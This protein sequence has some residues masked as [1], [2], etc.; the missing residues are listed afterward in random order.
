[1][2]ATASVDRSSAPRDLVEPPRSKHDVGDLDGH[3]RAA[4]DGDADVGLAQRERIVHA[5]ADHRDDPPLGPQLADEP[6]LVLGQEIG[7]VV[8]EA[9]RARR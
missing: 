8:L 6:R 5:V 7:V 4:G 2:P 1:M 3:G 9:E